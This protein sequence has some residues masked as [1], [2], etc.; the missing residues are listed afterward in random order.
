MK[1]DKPS[2]G[3]L[4]SHTCILCIL[5]YI[6]MGSVDDVHFLG[7]RTISYD[8][9]NGFLLNNQTVKLSGLH[10]DSGIWRSC[11]GTG[12]GKKAAKTERCRLHRYTHIAPSLSDRVHHVCDYLGFMV[13]DEALMNG[14]WADRGLI[15][16]PTGN[17]F[18]AITCILINGMRP[19]SA[20][21]QR[22][23]NHPSCHYG[24]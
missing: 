18:T 13:M 1:V 12:M 10:Q 14:R 4:K 19:I 11:S 17:T 22:D 5:S 2:R 23:R 9:E 24:A 15:N 3:L 6:L 8:S 20:M 7:I 21:L 16:G